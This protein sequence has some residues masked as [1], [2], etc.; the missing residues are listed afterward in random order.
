MNPYFLA[1][2][3]IA[4]ALFEGTL[5][6]WAVAELLQT[7][8]R[9]RPEATTRDRS[10]RPII[11]VCAMAALLLAAFARTRVTGLDFPNNALTFVA[12]L[13]IVWAGIGLRWWCFAVLGRYFTMDVM[14]SAGQPVITGGPYRFVRHPSYAALLLIVAGIG[15]VEANWLALA[16]LILLPLFGLMNRIRV[17]EA[18]LSATLGDPYRA[19]AAIHKRLI[20]FI[21]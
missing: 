12:G 20:P 13:A 2:H 17:E 1:S 19:Y 16:A 7:T 6:L 10:S 9:R 18:A 21:W 4:R 5:A 3:P 11:A 8:L 15:V 14:T